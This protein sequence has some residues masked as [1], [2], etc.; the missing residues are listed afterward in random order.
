VTAAITTA[1]RTTRS[2]Q[3]RDDLCRVFRKNRAP[4]YFI[5]ASPFN[6][7]GAEEWI[8]NLTFVNT[9]DSFDGR[10]LNV[11]VTGR[12]RLQGLDL[13]AL[14]HVLLR[15]PATADFFRE[16]GSFGKALFLMFDEESERLARGLGLEI[17]LPPGVPAASPR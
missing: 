17:C 12:G 16:R 11:F 2:R 5:N 8:G 9:S 6:L 4:I 10:H 13:V 1:L 7:L 15:D 3:T 14:N